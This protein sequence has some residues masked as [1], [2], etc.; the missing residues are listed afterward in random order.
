MNI[1]GTGTPSVLIVALA[2]RDPVTRLA[3]LALQDDPAEHAFIDDYFSAEGPRGATEMAELAASS[4][5]LG[6]VV[7][8]AI[9]AETEAIVVRRGTFDAAF[10]AAHPRVRFVQRIGRRP[11]GV[12]VAA[13]KAAG[14][15]VACLPRPAIMRTAEHALL[16]MLASGKAMRRGEA[17]MR[18]GTVAPDA[19]AQDEVAY[20]WTGLD[21]AGLCGETIG[22]IGLGEVG[23]ELAAR[24]RPFEAR[25][26]YW[27]RTRAP[28]GD[29][30]ELGVQWSDLDALLAASRYV[31]IALAATPQTQGWM[32]AA[33]FARMRRDAFFINV[34]R[35]KLV[36]ER[37]LHAALVERRIAGAGLDVHAVEPSPWD[38]LRALDN[39]V[40]SPHVAGGMRTGIIDEVRAI[41]AN[42][43]AYATGTP[44]AGLV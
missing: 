44:P 1:R 32:D 8:D 18:A 9:D 5:D 3:G 29:E 7:R 39:V 42:V 11:A 24:L 14:V 36:D 21:V 2:D 23:A 20:N 15:L 40:V 41:V 33:K 43:R 28:L 17:R 31:C 12:D 6:A 30:R 4:R 26:L 27:K 16:L 25:V 10:F 19:R 13:A 34:S 22:L 38:E 35:G 37:A